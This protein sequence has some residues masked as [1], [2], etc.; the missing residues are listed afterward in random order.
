MSCCGR[1]L[2]DICR[3]TKVPAYIDFAEAELGE[4]VAIYLRR[5]RWLTADL[6]PGSVPPAAQ[7]RNS[8]QVV[9]RSGPVWPA[10]VAPPVGFEPTLPAPEADALSPELWGLRR[11]KEYQCTSPSRTRQRIGPRL[12]L[13]AMSGAAEGHVQCCARLSCEQMPPRA[14]WTR[15]TTVDHDQVTAVPGA[16]YSSWRR[17]RHPQP[18]SRGPTSV[19]TM[20]ETLRSSMTMTSALRTRRCWRG[21]EVT[22]ALRLAVGAS[23]LGDGLGSVLAALQAAGHAPLVAGQVADS[24]S[25][26]RGLAI[27]CPS[28]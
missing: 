6:G 28:R 7:P 14:G 16:L 1:S 15:G 24:R 2:H 18:R 11:G 17:T 25:K 9:C 20:P 12:S 4:Q 3:R 10:Q 26:W 13:F 22:R 19:L 23:D 5:E 21:Q 8:A 27:R